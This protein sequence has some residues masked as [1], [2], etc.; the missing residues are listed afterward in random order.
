MI[1]KTEQ[2]KWRR[3][4]MVRAL[5][6]N[7]RRHREGKLDPIKG[8]VMTTAALHSM[9]EIDHFKHPVRRLRCAPNYNSTVVVRCRST[10]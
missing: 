9:L 8:K 1:S 2:N 3:Q 6:C 10:C 4:E 7:D 5:T